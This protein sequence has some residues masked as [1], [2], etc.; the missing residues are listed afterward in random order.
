MILN[1]SETNEKTEDHATLHLKAGFCLLLLVHASCFF[2]PITH[3]TFSCHLPSL[4]G[5]LTDQQN[6]FAHQPTSL[7]QHRPTRSYHQASLDPDFGLLV[8]FI[9]CLVFYWKRLFFF[10]GWWTFVI[11]L[12]I[13][14]VGCVDCRVDEEPA[15]VPARGW[16]G[17]DSWEGVCVFRLW[18]LCGNAGYPSS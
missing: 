10:V 3:L 14:V 5:F 17:K 12:S 6:H 13:S 11:Y 9:T 2:L 8:I 16:G 15:C 4:H 1:W 18:L 7:Q